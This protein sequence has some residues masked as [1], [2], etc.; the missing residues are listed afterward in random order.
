MKKLFATAMG[1]AVMFSVTQV[2]AAPSIEEFIQ[3][4]APASSY[5]NCAYKMQIANKKCLVTLTNV[6]SSI[7]SRAKKIFGSRADL[8]L[9]TIK[10]PDGDVGRYLDIG[11]DEVYKLINLGDSRSYHYKTD[12]NDGFSLNFYNGL[13]IQDQNNKEHIRLW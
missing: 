6:K 4:E 5:Y 10:W 2:R 1:L 9:L 8:E 11:G 3:E 12:N 7:D 13:V